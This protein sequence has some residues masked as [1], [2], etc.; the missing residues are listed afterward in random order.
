[1]RDGHG[2]GKLCP[3]TSRPL[4]VAYFSPSWPPAA[5]ANGISTYVGSI[6]AALEAHNVESHILT[7]WLP[8]GHSE[9]KVHLVTEPAQPSLGAK[10]LYNVAE[11]VSP[12]A[13]VI[14]RLGH[15]LSRAVT[16]LDRRWPVDLLEVEES[17]G[18]AAQVR[19]RFRKP[20]VVRLHGPWCVVGP[21]LG[22]QR[23][24]GFA[25]R[26]LAEYSAIRSADALSSPSQAALDIVRRAYRL[27][28]AAAEVVP[29]P[30]PLPAAADVWSYDGCEKQ[31]VLFVGRF[32]RVKGA[33]LVLDAFGRIATS[34]PE[35]KLWFVGPDQG[36][37]EGTRKWKLD[38]Y[39]AA[40]LNDAAR[41]R[42]RVFGALPR[43]RVAELRRRAQVTVV[44]SRYETFPMT[45][46]EALGVG[47]PVITSLAGGIA[48]IAR[49]GSNCLAFESGNTSE[50]AGRLADL[51]GDVDLA[52]RLGRQ[53]REDCEQRFS[54]DVV[55]R[56]MRAFYDRVCQTP[57]RRS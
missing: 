27:P 1:M 32:D 23:D 24:V 2:E 31:T 41:Q 42:V 10:I 46:L 48:E 34:F 25:L 38:E 16:E 56:R 55:A 22:V 35:A 29:N 40:K 33:D 37:L 26:Y 30:A 51:L 4:R 18:M 14:F 13:S 7:P 53:A 47:C 3:V 6:R 12:N 9:P 54:P 20:V 19:R 21:A 11:R 15:N 44:A 50:L 17:F 43:E 57:A 39:L 8:A 49:P 36:L 5:S 52:R 28:L 45:L